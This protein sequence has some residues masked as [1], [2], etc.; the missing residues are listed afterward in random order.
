MVFLLVIWTIYCSCPYCYG[1]E[2]FSKCCSTGSYRSYNVFG[3]DSKT[4]KFGTVLV[5][6]KWFFSCWKCVF[7]ADILSLEAK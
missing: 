3:M 7:V 2:Q 1:V 5:C 6:C 4:T